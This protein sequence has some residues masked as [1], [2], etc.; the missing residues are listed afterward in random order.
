MPLS[1]LVC[2]HCEQSVDVSVTSVT[3]SRE[4]PNCGKPIMLQFTTKE[5]RI[6]RKALLMPAADP[7]GNPD[8]DTQQVHLE[9]RVL[10]GDIHGRMLHSPD[11]QQNA[12]QFLWGAGIVLGLIV[13]AVLADTFEWWTSLGNGIEA[14]KRSVSAAPAISEDEQELPL[15]SEPAPARRP[16]L[17]RAATAMADPLPAPVSSPVVIKAGSP[18][19]EQDQAAL[20]V[21]SF[22]RAKDVE[23]RLRFV[24]DSKL[25]EPRIRAYYATHP[26]GPIPFDRVELQEVDPLGARTFSFRVVMPDGQERRALVGGSVAGGWFVDWASFVAYGEMDWEEFVARKPVTPVLMRVM[27]AS[28]EHFDH[29]FPDPARLVCLKLTNVLKPATPPLFAYAVRGSLV[30]RAVEFVMRGAD[31][32]KPLTLTLKYPGN[33]GSDSTNQV[34][35]DEMVAEGWMLRGR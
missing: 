30:G 33:G 28:D 24:R 2:P 10:E 22:L 1:R 19:S 8:E 13:V 9:P 32:T 34:W 35:I 21:G 20:A 23:E 6:K 25:M 12:K 18:L 15:T 3:R 14:L 11:V 17:D 5:K 4:C 7:L 16:R 31:G 29:N 26:D 27:A